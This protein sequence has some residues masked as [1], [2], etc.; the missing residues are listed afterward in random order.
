MISRRCDQTGIIQ[1]YA[2]VLGAICVCYLKSEIKRH[3]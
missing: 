1:I 2:K 3:L